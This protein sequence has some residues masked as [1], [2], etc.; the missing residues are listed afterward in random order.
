MDQLT[1]TLLLDY[2]YNRFAVTLVLCSV[3]V[4][5]KNIINDISYK[6]KVSIGK[7]VASSMFST[8]LMCA[9]KDYIDIT[10][11]VYVLTCV[12]VGMWSTKI[13]SLVADSKFMGKVTKRLLKSIASPVADAVSDVLD[14]EE[15][16]NN[17][18]ID[19]KPTTV[20]DNDN[21][22]KK[23]KEEG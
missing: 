7:T 22:S 6:R 18:G 19:N 4:V 10:F 3:G 13:I 21:L 9:V 12:I 16:K 23:Y 5:I 17:D 11:S 14:E 20:D 8:V 2:I 15:N 1:F